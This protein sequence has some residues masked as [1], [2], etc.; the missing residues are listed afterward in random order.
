[1]TIHHDGVG[2]TPQQRAAASARRPQRHDRRF[3]SGIVSI[4]EGH[5]IALFSQGCAMRRES[6]AGPE[7]PPKN[8][9]PPIQMCDGLDHNLPKEFETLLCRCNAHARRKFVT[10]PRAS[11]AKYASC[12]TPSRRSTKLTPMH[13]KS[14]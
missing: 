5:R 4:G 1:M 10:W 8:L 9:P 13:A 14:A 2:L 7:T 6:H 12:C 3:T 11:L